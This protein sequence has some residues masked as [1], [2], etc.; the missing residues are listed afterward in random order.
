M[1]AKKTILITGGARSGK[2]RYAERRA[3][4]LGPRRVYIATATAQDEEMTR[5]IAE[6][7]KHRDEEWVTIEEPIEITSLLLA[8]RGSIDCAVVE[9]LTLWLS[10][11]LLQRDAKIAKDRVQELLEILPTLDFNTV[12]VSNEVGWGIVPD[13]VLARSFRD[14]AGWANQRIAA[15]ANE[16]VLMVAGIPNVVKK[17]TGCS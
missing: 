11:L 16:V 14:L 6:H 9:C 4:E 8:Q 1:I 7:R 2:S 13:N 10:N 5:R 17:E 3:A 12:F 15:L